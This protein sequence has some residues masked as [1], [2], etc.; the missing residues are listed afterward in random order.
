MPKTKSE[1]AP[2]AEPEPEL[3]AVEIWAERHGLLPELTEAPTVMGSATGG[4]N[5]HAWKFRATKVF[6]RWSDGQQVTEAEFLA[7]VR[8]MESQA[9]R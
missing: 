6:K 2:V 1:V 4:R 8:D 9:H 3:A 5:P 7:A